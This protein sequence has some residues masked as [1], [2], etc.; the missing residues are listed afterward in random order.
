MLETEAIWLRRYGRVM[1]SLIVLVALVSIGLVAAERKA[2]LSRP[3]AVP[4]P[5]SLPPDSTMEEQLAW[6]RQ[7]V[8]W[9][10]QGGYIR[11]VSG[12]ETRGSVITVADKE[13][14]LPDDAYVKA[15][16]VMDEPPSNHAPYYVIQR[17]NSTITISERTGYVLNLKLDEADRKPFDFLKK[18]IKGYLE[19]VERLK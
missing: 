4:Y 9:A 12:E 19:G 17:G 2:G 1:F 14:R 10:E 5:E 8:E 13:I 15:F 18:H 3:E 7:F 16:I 11:H 6:K